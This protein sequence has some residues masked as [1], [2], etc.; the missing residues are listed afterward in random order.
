[1]DKNDLLKQIAEA[2]YNIGYGA[3]KHFATY[4]IV[5][6]VPNIH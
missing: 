6:K 2:S 3:K 4:D 5:E 1:M